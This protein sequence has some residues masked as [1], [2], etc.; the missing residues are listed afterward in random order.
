MKKAILALILISLVLGSV[1]AQAEAEKYPVR[2]IT[3]IAIMAPGGGTDLVAR[4]LSAEMGKAMGVNINVTNIT[5]ASGT[6]GME[7]ILKRPADGYTL[8]GIPETIATTAAMGYWN[9]SVDVF[10][11]FILGGSPDLISVAGDSPYN[12]LEELMAAAKKAPKQIKAAAAANGGMH[13]INLASFEKGAGVAFNYIPYEG[14]IPSQ[15]AVL[16]KEVD[17][18]VT[19]IAEQ[20]PLIKAGKLK[21]LAMLIPETF[22]FEGKVIPSAFDSVEGLDRYLPI[23]QTIGLGV[24]KNAPQFVKD[25]LVAA[26][27]TAMQSEGVQKFAGDNYYVV[28]GLYGE[29]ASANMRKLES[30]FAWALADLGI[31]KQ[32]PASLGIPRP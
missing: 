19:T 15:N 16:S 9:K 20:A 5:G 31:A 23:P 24:N 30:L 28:S 4:V 17:V 2:D 21:P 3:T 25:K 1:F 11:Y 7:E 14:S 26:F 10:D 12:T 13:H 32:D 22:T 27:K 8:G 6:V 29:E 18:V